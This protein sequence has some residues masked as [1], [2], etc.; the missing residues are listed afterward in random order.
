MQKKI[1]KFGN[2]IGITFDRVIQEITGIRKNDCLEVK[3]SK[4]KLVVK[5]I[6]KGE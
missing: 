3:C 5:K 6:E 1:I 2:S 4:D